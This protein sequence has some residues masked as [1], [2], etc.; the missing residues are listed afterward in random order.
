MQAISTS[1]AAP[2]PPTRPSEPSLAT[3]RDEDFGYAQARHLLFRAGFGGTDRQIRELAAMGP[4][5]AVEHLVE[6]HD[7][8]CE[9]DAADAFDRDIISPLSDR[10]RRAL[11]RARLRGDEDT[12]ARFR[13]RRQRA[14]QADRRQI[15]EIQRWWITRMIRTP[16]PLEEKMTLFWHGHFA[17]SYR[18][19]EDSYHMYQQNRMLREHATGHLGDLILGILRDPAMLRSLNNNRNRKRSPNENLAREL[20]ELFSLGEGRYTERDIKETARVLT[21]FTYEDDDFRFNR[22]AHDNGVKRV[23][24]ARGNLGAV[25]L[26]NA[27]LR[28]RACAEFIA[29]KLYRFFV[30]DIPMDP[31]E[32]DAVTRRAVLGIADMLRRANYRIG[33]VLGE[34]FLSRHFYD[35]A[36]TGTMIKS[37]ADLLVG[38]VRS[39][40]VPVRDLGTAADAMK[41]MGQQLFVPPSVKGWDGGRSWI[42]TSTLFIRQNLLVYMLTGACRPG[43]GIRSRPTATTRAGSS[44]RSS[45]PAPAPPPTSGSPPSSRN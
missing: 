17:T 6:Y 33:P 27:I 14:Q 28:R 23:L 5:R 40:G 24:G 31:R 21:G 8:P 30:R 22:D 7:I 36:N 42:N 37:P 1:A 9:P 32:T 29:T 4:R 11:Y 12:L 25:D 13:V 39:L 45:I 20:L 38:A 35:P 16:R 19:V 10:E 2:A 34:L 43:A 26:V 15:V 3:I 18:V 44:P 41:L